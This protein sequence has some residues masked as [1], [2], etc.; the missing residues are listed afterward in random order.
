M[1]AIERPPVEQHQRA[2]EQRCG[3]E[4]VVAVAEIDEHRRIGER[5]QQPQP[6][7]TRVGLRLTTP[8]PQAGGGIRQRIIQIETR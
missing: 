8:A 1:P 5:E 4:S 2:A 3:Q 7:P 6:S